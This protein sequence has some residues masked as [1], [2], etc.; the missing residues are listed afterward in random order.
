[1][2]RMIRL[3]ALLVCAAMLLSTSAVASGAQIEIKDITLSDGGENFLDFSGLGIT[4][5][6]AENAGGMGL[7]LGVN[8]GGAKAAAVQLCLQDDKILL[9]ADGVNT[10]Y[11]VDLN[12]VISLIR[13]QLPDM[14][15][16]SLSPA[17]QAAAEAIVQEAM[18]V[19]GN[20]VTPLQTYEMDGVSYQIYNISI[21]ADQI[22]G[23][24]AKIAALLDKHPELAAQMGV[25]RFADVFKDMPNRISVEGFAA[26]SDRGFDCEVYLVGTHKGNGERYGVCISAAGASEYDAAAG[27][28]AI[29]VKVDMGEGL[30]E[31]GFESEF[32]IDTYALM[33]KGRFVSFE[34]DMHDADFEDEGVYAV[35]T[36]P[37]M[38]DNGHWSFN[39]VTLDGSAGFELDCDVDDGTAVMFADDEYIS[40]NYEMS[41]VNYVNG[42]Y[43]LDMN[44]DGERIIANASSSITPDDG[45]WIIPAGGATVDV[46]NLTEAQMNVLKMEAMTVGLTAMAK[47]AAVSPL[48]ASLLGN[49]S[50]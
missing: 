15:N 38:S 50:F 32:I 16:F 20:A 27:A 22:D 31:E 26:V 23:L 14:R 47:M 35:C 5:G 25:E 9:G 3:I 13:T 45:A 18:M 17:D 28:E 30:P 44:I 40:F 41:G 2:K 8:A 37:V 6:A 39:V 19:F 36:S 34:V 29:A 10:V 21:S 48:I 1:M 12:S 46:L 4:L 43:N 7:Q 42:K 11:S 33:V 24:L 49:M